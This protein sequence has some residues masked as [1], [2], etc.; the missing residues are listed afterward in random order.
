MQQSSTVVVLTMGPANLPAVRIWTAKTGRFSSRPVENPDPLLLGGPNPDPYPSTH[1]F[2]QLWQDP[3]V[4]ICDSVS[5]VSQC[6][7]AFRYATSNRKI[8]AFVQRCLFWIYW[9]PWW[10]K[11]TEASSLPI[12]RISVNG[13]SMIVGRVSWA[14]WEVI[15]CR[16]P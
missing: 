2:C 10:S 13:A 16:Q 14:F 3:L 4:R 6:I 5:R 11:H 15:G 9:P 12:L 1:K 8:L 7:V